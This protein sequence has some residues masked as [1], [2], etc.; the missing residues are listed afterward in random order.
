VRPPLDLGTK[1]E[2]ATSATEGHDGPGHVGIPALIQ[3]HVAGLGET[4]DIGDVASVDEVF[5]VDEWRHGGERIC[6]CGSV[7][8][9]T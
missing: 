2:H 9:D 3:A 1:P 4:K 8:Q 6:E 5:G 7:R